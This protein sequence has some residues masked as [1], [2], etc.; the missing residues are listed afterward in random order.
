MTVFILFGGNAFQQ[1]V[2]SAIVQHVFV[3]LYDAGLSGGHLVQQTKFFVEELLPLFFQLKTLFLLLVNFKNLFD[4]VIKCFF[5]IEHFFD[6]SPIHPFWV[7]LRNQ[8][9]SVAIV[10]I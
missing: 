6:D 9:I 8:E 2:L 3:M 7:C 4:G 1:S 5:C 10:K